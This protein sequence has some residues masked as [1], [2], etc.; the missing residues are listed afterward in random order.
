MD[1]LNQATMMKEQ[2]VTAALSDHPDHAIHLNNLGISLQRRFE[3][4]GSLNGLNQSITTYKQAAA[5]TPINHADYT[6]YLGRI[7]Q[8]R[9]E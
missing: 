2:T 4:T 3:R 8:R 7:L 5:I 9:F 1:D 6:T